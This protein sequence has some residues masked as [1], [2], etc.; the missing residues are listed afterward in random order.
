LIMRTKF[1]IILSLKT[2]AG[3][4][5]YGQFDFGHDQ[6]AAYLLFESLKG[7]S[8]PDGLS[9]LHIDLM[10]TVDELPVKI[11]T[12]SCTLGELAC[13]AKLI[14]REIFR[15]KNLKSYEE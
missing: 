13:N 11:K 12:I 6:E 10:E 7:K 5:S 9:L 1:Y 2:S 15:Q 3:F 8:E 4:E 14:A